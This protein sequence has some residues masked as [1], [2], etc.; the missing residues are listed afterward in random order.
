[1][2]CVVVVD[3]RFWWG[4]QSSAHDVPD[5]AFDRNRNLLRFA[6]WSE[7]SWLG[8][9]AD[10]SANDVLPPCKGIAVHVTVRVSVSH[11]R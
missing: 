8:E 3:M 9:A 2:V 6:W 10:S 1:M 4:H 11:I 5:M 7:Q